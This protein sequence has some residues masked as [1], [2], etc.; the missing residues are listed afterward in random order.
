MS[1]AQNSG[2]GP[3]ADSSTRVS[4]RRF[5]IAFVIFGTVGTISARS[6]TFPSGLRFATMRGA[7]T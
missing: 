7:G 2:A 6:A 4:P 3:S 1:R 5:A